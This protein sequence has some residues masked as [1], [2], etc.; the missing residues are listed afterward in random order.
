MAPGVIIDPSE[1]TIEITD[2]DGMINSC[3]FFSFIQL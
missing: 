3:L 2:V 1:T